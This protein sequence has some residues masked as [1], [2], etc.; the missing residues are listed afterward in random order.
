[1]PAPSPV[2]LAHREDVDSLIELDPIAARDSGRRQFIA[3]AVASEQC[4]VAT[5]VNDASALLGY[6]VLNRAFFEHDFIPLVMVKE[7]ARRRGIATAIVQTLVWQCRGAKLFTSTNTSNMPM[8]QLL[9]RLGFIESG[10][11]EN[12][13]DQD[14][15]MIFVKR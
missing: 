4:W 5:D 13:D 15:E 6:G 2:R 3:Q 14:P 11:V 1:M 7:S 9:G 8:R 12:L 10:R